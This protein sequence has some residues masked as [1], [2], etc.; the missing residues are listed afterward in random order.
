MGRWAPQETWNGTWPLFNHPNNSKAP[1]PKLFCMHAYT[2]LEG[3]TQGPTSIQ[4]F[5]ALLSNQG[6]CSFLDM[7]KSRGPPRTV[8]SGYRY[9]LP[10]FSAVDGGEAA[11]FWDVRAPKAHEPGCPSPHS[12]LRDLESD[13]VPGGATSHALLFLLQNASEDWSEV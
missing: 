11:T 12:P 9:R 1:S 13:E 3:P 7:L 5:T 10:T 4:S 8:R 6:K 2:H